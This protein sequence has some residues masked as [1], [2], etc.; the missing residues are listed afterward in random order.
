M[1]VTALG[2]ASSSCA[3]G[4]GVAVNEGDFAVMRPLSASLPGDE[5]RFRAIFEHAAIGIGFTDAGGRILRANAALCGILGA[6]EV[7]IL[8]ALKDGDSYGAHCSMPQ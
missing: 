4:G 5:E 7:D 2:T 8:P 1:R 3:T 6:A